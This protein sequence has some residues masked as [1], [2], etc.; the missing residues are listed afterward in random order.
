MYGLRTD[1]L[2]LDTIYFKTLQDSVQVKFYSG[3]K[4][5]ANKRQ[6]A[7]DISLNGYIG[8][9]DAQLAIGYLN[10]KRE[11]GVDLGLK[12]QL[13]P[14]GISMHIT[15]DNPT[16]VYRPF[17]VNHGNYIYLSDEDVSMP[18]SRY[19]MRIIPDYPYILLRTLSYSRILP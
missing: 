12:A 4:A 10:G 3:V 16:L 11:T 19:T 14:N 5:L 2:Q 9:T 15:P 13:R 7:F 17:K 8:S 1:S 6:E 18:T